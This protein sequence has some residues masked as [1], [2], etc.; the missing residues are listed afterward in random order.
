MF[1][2]GSVV[3]EFINQPSKYH[4]RGLT[5]D[6][7]SRKAKA[8]VELGIEVVPGDLNDFASLQSAFNDAHIIYAMT[9]FWQEMSFDV[10]YR[11]GKDIA[12]IAASLPQLEHFV[13]AA[14]PDGKA[15]SEGKF[16][17]IYHWQ[18]KAAVTDYIRESQP[19]LWAKT[20]AVLFPNYFENCKV[21]PHAYLPVKVYN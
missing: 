20:T 15:I 8:L 11:Q 16:P 9:D 2:G 3:K 18:S 14:L 21:R 1:Q 4:V 5:R 13:W 19:D 7:N 6:V 12:D 17:H 10:E